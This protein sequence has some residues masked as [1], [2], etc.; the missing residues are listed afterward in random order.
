VTG[1][2]AHRFAVAAFDTW[3]DAYKVAR[4]LCSGSNPLSGVSY[5][6]LQG[7]LSGAPVHPLSTL[8]FPGNAAPIVCSTGPI[9]ERLTARLD[10]GTPSLQAALVAWLIPRHAA[11]L[12][13]TVDSGK[14]VLWVQLADHADEQR[15]YRTLKAAGCTSVG[16]HDLVGG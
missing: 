2:A 6:G 15:A 10:A 13:R 4:E 3:V 1:R 7:V 14:I 11:Q 16:V 9:A 8:P 12:Q 5:M